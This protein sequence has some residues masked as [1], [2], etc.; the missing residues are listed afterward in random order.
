MALTTNQAYAKLKT[1]DFSA[2]DKPGTNKGARGQLLENALG[3]ANS[4]TLLDLSDGE[5]KSFTI[6]QTICVTQVK[7]CLE[8]I[9]DKGVEFEDSK[10]GK[11]LAQ[12]LYV[13]FTKDN[14]YVGT[15]LVNEELD[16]EHYIKLAED[17]GYISAK[18]RFAYD[19]KLE[20]H[21]TTGPNKL[22]QIRTKAAKNAHGEYT[23]MCY[24]GVVLK[25]KYMAFYLLST[26]GKEVLK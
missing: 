25:D 20:L 24:N 12:T 18:I 17:Y 3:L 8:D 1:T 10:V 7:H 14:D 4:T 15:K 2:F 6:G 23:K 19:N 16:K 26:F 9:I 22:L 21:T 13:G 5:I 11:K